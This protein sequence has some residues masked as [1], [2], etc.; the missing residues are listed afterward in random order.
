MLTIRIALRKTNCNMF[1]IKEELKTLFHS[2]L[3]L[4]YS[5]INLFS[6]N[7]NSKTTKN[8]LRIL[9]KIIKLNKMLEKLM[10]RQSL[11]RYLFNKV[12][13]LIWAF[14]LIMVSNIIRK[15]KRRSIKVGRILSNNKMIIKGLNRI[16]WLKKIYKR[17]RDHNIKENSN[18]PDSKLKKSNR[19][20]STNSLKIEL[21]INNSDKLIDKFNIAK[22][23]SSVFSLKYKITIET[24]SLKQKMF[25]SKWHNSPNNVM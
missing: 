7:P 24:S 15:D 4:K 12:I 21:T 3:R 10:S 25:L 17:F 23:M 1:L 22:L 6:R 9:K 18:S 14:M 8:K 13:F 11:R 20:K 19:I 5:Q 2:Q 16:S